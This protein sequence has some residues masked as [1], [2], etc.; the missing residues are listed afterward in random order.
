MCRG[1]IKHFM[2]KAC[3]NALLMKENLKKRKIIDEDMCH[4]CSTQPK[5]SLHALW[6]CASIRQVWDA[7]FHW[8]NRHLASNGTS[9]NLQDLGL[10]KPHMLELFAVITWF[11][12]S[13]RNKVRL[14]Q[15]VVPL[16]RVV[17]EA[18]RYLS[19]HKL[20]RM[21]KLQLLRSAGMKWR[22]PDRIGYKT[23]FDGAMFHDTG[24]AGLGIVIQNHE[25]EVM[26]ALSEE[27]PQPSLVTL[28]ELL[29]AR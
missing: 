15:D 24:E 8:I 18:K 3:T 21:T 5:S 9:E 28:L 27:I 11:L 19:L 6:D 25:G 20:V 22:L 23:N 1:K 2:R 4:Q 10:E 12:W 17:F 14:K 13:R 26:V 7:D 29:A 16:N